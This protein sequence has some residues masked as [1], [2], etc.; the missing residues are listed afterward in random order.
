MCTY[1][2]FSSHGN[3]SVIEKYIEQDL[4]Y[5]VSTYAFLTWR[6]WKIK[7]QA[8]MPKYRVEDGWL[9]NGRRHRNQGKKY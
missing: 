8:I 2:S 3:P 4:P 7:G 6:H 9:D 5:D 1:V